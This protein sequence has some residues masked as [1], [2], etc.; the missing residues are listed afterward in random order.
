MK[1]GNGRAQSSK[2]TKRVVSL[3]SREG[4]HEGSEP[5]AQDIIN[6]DNRKVTH[7]INLRDNLNNKP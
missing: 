3:K 6:I 2:I 4:L 5:L 1:K 7:F